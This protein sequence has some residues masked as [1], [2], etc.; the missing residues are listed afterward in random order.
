MMTTRAKE[1]ITIDKE[2]LEI[3]EFVLDSNLFLI[4]NSLV[5][6]IF[7]GGFL[8]YLICLYFYVGKL[9]LLVFISASVVF[10]SL[11]LFGVMGMKSISR[12]KHYIERLSSL[13]EE[14]I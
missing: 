9:D 5:M 12:Q 7:F 2:K 1:M 6:V 10:S 4:S 14:T 11:L 13:Y 3:K 8:Y